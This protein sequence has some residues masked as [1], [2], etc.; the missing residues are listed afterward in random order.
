MDRTNRSSNKTV[1][2]DQVRTEAALTV[3]KAWQ[4][5]AKIGDVAAAAILKRAGEEAFGEEAFGAALVEAVKE[6]D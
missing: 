2:D 3:A 4:R 5:M 6:A 1:S